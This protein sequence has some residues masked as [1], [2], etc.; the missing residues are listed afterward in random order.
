MP[1]PVPQPPIHNVDDLCFALFEP[2]RQ[3]FVSLGV[4]QNTEWLCYRPTPLRPLS[5]AST[6]NMRHVMWRMAARRDGDGMTDRLASIAALRI[7]EPA[8]KAIQPDCFGS[9]SEYDNARAR[10]HVFGCTGMLSMEQALQSIERHFNLYPERDDRYFVMLEN[11]LGQQPN[12][13]TSLHAL[14]QQVPMLG[15][16]RSFFLPDQN[17]LVLL[18]LFYPGRLSLLYD[19]H[20]QCLL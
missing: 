9:L 5:L 6:R 16:R 19:L 10:R 14:Q 2:S 13:E 18:R 1:S 7:V 8:G 4:N 12:D 20:Q 11:R 17:A 15:R 3:Q